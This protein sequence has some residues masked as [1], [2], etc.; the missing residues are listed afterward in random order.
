MLKP[1]SKPKPSLT[2]SSFGGLQNRALSLPT[3]LSL[4]SSL[5]LLRGRGSRPLLAIHRFA[6]VSWLG[7][8]R[9]ALL[10]CLAL[11]SLPWLHCLVCPALSLCIALPCFLC[12]AFFCLGESPCC[13]LPYLASHDALPC[14]GVRVV[15]SVR[16]T[17]TVGEL[18]FFLFGWDAII[19]LRFGNDCLCRLIISTSHDVHKSRPTIRFRVIVLV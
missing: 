5:C 10:W 2:V 12:L 16:V 1:K 4:S 11:A 6:W 13:A 14:L 15:F 7:L 18:L 19:L 17:V 8:P 9:F 3:S